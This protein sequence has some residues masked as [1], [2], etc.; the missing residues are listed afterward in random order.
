MEEASGF[1]S[2]VRRTRF[3]FAVACLGV[4]ALVAAGCGDDDGGGGGEVQSVTVTLPFQ[5]SIVWTG[6]EIARDP[7]GIYESDY[8]IKAETVA[9]E[10]GSFV[11]QQLIA[12]QID[13][14][15]TGT[16][17]TIIAN[18]EGHDLIGIASIESDVFTIVSTPEAGVKSIDDLEG[19]ALG[20][21]DL[22]GGEIPLVNAVL[23]D[24]GLTP[25]ENIELK[26]IGPGGPAAAKAI[27]DGEVDA[28]AA[29]IND[30]AGIEVTGVEFVPILEPKFQDLPND[31]MVVRAELLEDP[32]KLQPVLDIMAGWYKGTVFGEENPADGLAI[33]CE[34]VPEDCQDMGVAEGFYDASVAIGIDEARVGGEHDYAKLTIVR[35]AIAAVDNPAALD[36]NIE[37]VFPNTY[38][39]ELTP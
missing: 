18:A 17:E 29:A 7:G 36:V 27:Q 24:H 4:L 35:D 13:F 6:Y 21:T 1:L 22:G 3:I 30:L 37:E 34:L 20:V 19:K 26:V 11:I 28:Y 10:G 33:I 5:D 14:G 8:N 23:A 12:G 2:R 25:D 9:T 32:D 39:E 16:P 38:S 31:E 15:I